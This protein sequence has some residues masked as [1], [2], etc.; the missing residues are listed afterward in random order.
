MSEHKLPPA[1]FLLGPTATGKTAL[2]ESIAA[3]WP[4]DVISVDSA[5]VYR[6]MDIGSAKPDREL[7]QRLPHRLIDIREPWD[8]YSVADFRRDALVQ[9]QSITA[10]GRIPL[11]VGGT[12]LYFKAL[13]EGLADLPEADASIRAEL[14]QE[15]GRLGWAALHE[16]LASV[17]PDTAAAL[18]PRHSQ[19][20]LR[21]LEVYY[22]S[23]RPLSEL[24]R[25]QGGAELP[26]RVVQ[27][28]LLPADRGVLHQRI[29]QRFR[30]ML[31]QGFLDEVRG[32]RELG[33]LHRGLP[34][35]RAVGYRQ[36]WEHLDG[37]YDVD[38]FV[39]RG[40]AATRQLAKRQLT[41]LRKWDDLCRLVIKYPGSS[42]ID[43]EFSDDGAVHVIEG[44]DE[45]S[46]LSKISSQIQE[47]A[48]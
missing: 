5:L 39:E 22:L 19:R 37:E 2:A 43:P 41:W 45:A 25:E 42:G 18:H 27:F 44:W 9:M 40:I 24:Q 34:S 30:Q 46:I 36:A 3:R 17:D 32:L 35:V 13:L 26:Y 1:I 38:E 4:C 29:D 6:G 15:A 28:A 20:I 10:A 48:G 47:L 21:A 33:R 16:R 8:V 7:Q 11:L 12:M 31:E 14:E 23:G